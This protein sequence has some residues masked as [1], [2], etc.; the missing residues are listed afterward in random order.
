FSIDSARRV[1]YNPLDTTPFGIWPRGSTA[2]YDFSS[3]FV[4]H[5]RDGKEH[6][7]VCVRNEVRSASVYRIENGR[8]I[9][10]WTK[11]RPEG[12]SHTLSYGISTLQTNGY[13]RGY[14][15]TVYIYEGNPATDSVAKARFPL[16]Y[17]DGGFE[18]V[19]SCGDVNG[20]GFGD[21]AV[22]Y[23]AVNGSTLVVFLGEN[24][25]TAVPDADT[26]TFAL[27]ISSEHPVSSGQSLRVSLT[28]SK[29]GAYAITLYSLRGE[30]V[31]TLLSEQL[32]EG[33]HQRLLS[34]G[35]VPTGLYNVRLSGGGHSVDKGL[36]IV[37]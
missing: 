35:P 3:S 36:M 34:L 29:P 22:I 21:L 30:L 14:N 9:F 18:S 17:K 27:D 1:H 23:S 37:P 33:V 25:P 13:A 11:T 15:P 12:T 5:S 4:W 2:Y 7:L 28:I 20:D 19:C 6:T 10:R 24:S 8:F 26:S 32:P 31:S 16:Y